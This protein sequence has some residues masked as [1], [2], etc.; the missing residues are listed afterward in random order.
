MNN[1]T[2]NSG[3]KLFDNNRMG[4]N[5]GTHSSRRRHSPRH[6]RYSVSNY[7][8]PFITSVAISAIV[9]IVLLVFFFST[10]ANYK[11]ATTILLAQLDKKET[12]LRKTHLEVKQVRAE[13][14]TLVNKRLPDLGALEF[15]KVIDVHE[16]YVKNILFTQTRSGS[17]TAYE[18]K[19]LAE[20]NDREKVT[21]RIRVIVFNRSG[22][23]IGGATVMSSKLLH[24]GDSKSYSTELDIFIDSVPEYFHIEIN[25]AKNSATTL[26]KAADADSAVSK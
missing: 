5:S 14:N 24:S 26:L 23:Q 18:Y 19:I 8:L 6:R 21:P 2:S 15:D 12:E 11:E 20:N 17:N 25:V 16:G 3:E 4:S 9:V 7:K 1:T 10:M 22:I 13:I